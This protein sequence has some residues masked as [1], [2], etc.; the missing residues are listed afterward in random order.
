MTAHRRIL[1][2]CNAERDVPDFSFNAGISAGIPALNFAFASD[3][4]KGE[5]VNI[6]LLYLIKRAIGTKAKPG[7]LAKA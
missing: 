3:V 5:T 6:A 4:P 7:A 1:K 2:I